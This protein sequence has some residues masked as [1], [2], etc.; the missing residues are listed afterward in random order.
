MSALCRFACA[1]GFATLA[2]SSLSEIPFS[3]AQAAFRGLCLHSCDL[4]Y[5]VPVQPERESERYALV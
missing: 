3:P 1:T 2:A 5:Y 4:E